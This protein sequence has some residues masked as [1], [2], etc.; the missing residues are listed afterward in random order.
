MTGSHFSR[1]AVAHPHAGADMIADLLR[2]FSSVD[3]TDDFQ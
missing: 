1:G 3:Q 2:V